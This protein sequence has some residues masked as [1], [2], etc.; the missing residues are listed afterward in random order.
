MCGSCQGLPNFCD[1]HLSLTI[2][3][4]HHNKKKIQPWSTWFFGLCDIWLLYVM[5]KYHWTH[6]DGKIKDII[7]QNK[8]QNFIKRNAYNVWETISLIK[9]LSLQHIKPM[10]CTNSPQRI[11]Q[12][13]ENLQVNNIHED[14]ANDH[15][16]VT[17]IQVTSY[18]IILSH[19]IWWF[20]VT[21]MTKWDENG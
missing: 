16:V 20:L 11:K 3:L 7:R 15:N 14:E 2:I 10:W 6:V 1:W 12:K 13:R 19:T 8:L 18:Q 17:I 4:R 9:Y 21:F 5:K